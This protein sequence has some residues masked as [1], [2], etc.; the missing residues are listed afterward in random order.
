MRVSIYMQV[1]VCSHVLVFWGVFVLAGQSCH[2]D[3]LSRSNPLH[4]RVM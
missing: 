2:H 4:E 3:V 1:L